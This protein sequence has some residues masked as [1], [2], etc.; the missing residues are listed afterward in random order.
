MKIKQIL[1][2]SLISAAALVLAAL[3]VNGAT[4]VNLGT[5]ADFLVLAKSG[6]SNTGI[7]TDIVGNI[8]TS[9][10]ASTAIT[11]FDL[12]MDSSGEFA[13]SPRVTGKVFAA[14]Y[15]SPTPA[16]LST[17]VSDME[18]AY[19]DAAGRTNPDTLN[20]LDGN[21]DG[22]SFAAGLHK[23]T[24]AVTITSSITLDGGGDSSAVWIFQI[25]NRL[26]LASGAQILLTNGAVSDNIFW[27]TAEGA[28][29][30]TTSHFEGNLLTATDVSAMTG[31]T[32]NARILAQTAVT[33]DSNS[34]VTPVPESSAY[35]AIMGL[36]AIGILCLRRRPKA[37]RLI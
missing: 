22:Q 33:L 15:A 11:G 23:W 20:L 13:T 31:A 34:I 25:D 4:V 29:L 8:G 36:G 30:G 6:I 19:T 14:D 10:I 35:A 1:P 9:P 27:Q 7:S 5:S 28:T 18:T 17:A 2:S 16:Y 24:S 37:A 32:M 3:T 21:L 12:N 26:N